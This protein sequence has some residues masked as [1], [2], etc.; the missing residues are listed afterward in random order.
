MKLIFKLPGSQIC[1]HRKD[2]YPIRFL[3]SMTARLR[4]VAWLQG[5][6]WMIPG[7]VSWDPRDFGILRLS[8]GKAYS[9][10]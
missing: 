7:K 6:L 4:F 2:G 1:T 10:R 3:C 5:S 9:A 8:L